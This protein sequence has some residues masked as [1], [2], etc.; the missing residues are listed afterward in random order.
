MQ[1]Q[2]GPHGCPKKRNTIL[3]TNIILKI[4]MLDVLLELM[5][6]LKNLVKLILREF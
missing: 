3:N 5:I 4:A 6:T 1:D 2:P